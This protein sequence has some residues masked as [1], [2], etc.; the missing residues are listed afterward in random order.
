MEMYRVAKIQF[1][2]RQVISCR[3]R[4]AQ[5]VETVLYKPEDLGFDSRWRHW[6]FSSTESFRD[7]LQSWVRLILLQKRVPGIFSGG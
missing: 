5:L 1:L 3:Q 7:A 2:L 4:V 6:N